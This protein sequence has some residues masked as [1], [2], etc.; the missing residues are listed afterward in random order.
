MNPFLE[1]QLDLVTLGTVVDMVPLVG[2]NRT[3]T[4]VGL[5][6][7]DRRQRP[8]IRALCQVANVDPNQG[9]NGY[10]LGT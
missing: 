7:L 4:R 3:L 8:G 10:T 9:L 2:E 6:I 1:S 5:P